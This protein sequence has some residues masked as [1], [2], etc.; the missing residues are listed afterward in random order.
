M[1]D[2][3]RW[4]SAV[5]VPPIRRQDRR[6]AR[7][8]SRRATPVGR[9]T[10]SPWLRA[11]LAFLILVYVGRVHELIPGTSQIPFASMAVLVVVAGLLVGGY[12]SRFSRVIK[13]RTV[14]IAILFVGIAGVSVPF[15]LWMGGALTEWTALA[16]V[17]TICLLLP[18]AV[19]NPGQLTYITRTFV[20]A[21]AILVSGYVVESATGF[22]ALREAQMVTFDKNDV[23]LLAGMAIPFA[24]AWG[25]SADRK[26][27]VGWG[28]GA[29]LAAGVI[30][31]GSRGGFL[32]LACFG[33]IFFL[34]SP[35][36]T[37]GKKVAVVI[38]GT[39]IL[40]VTGSG[41]YWRQIGETFTDPTE[42]YNF[43]VREGRI[44]IW[45]R[46][47]HYLT[48]HPLTGVGIGN[49]PIAEG[50]YLEDEGYG[51]KWSTAHSS[52]VL[53]G[54]ELGIPGLLVFLA[55]L[56]A[57]AGQGRAAPRRFSSAGDPRLREVYRL[58]QATLYSLIVF[59]VAGAFLSAAYSAGPAF[60][61][62]VSAC[63]GCVLID[64]RQSGVPSRRPRP[65]NQALRTIRPRYQKPRTSA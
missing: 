45:K 53:V 5:S 34:R 15:A 16:K 38:I 3:Y 26:R 12:Q 49:F 52:Y 24:V 47:I 42:D 2:R 23:A 8:V 62:G 43:Q 21:A 55:L 29:F 57:I 36:L 40:A 50:Q 7:A 58:S 13:I 6:V 19:V 65:G 11:A 4:Q 64:V 20:V 1:N 59:T 35:M 32:A 63:L 30:S 31:T 54:A 10:W 51:V 17:W 18:L 33:L 25:A 46:G 61:V 9:Y 60:L 28:F 39:A 44:E 48:E 56:F 27:I 41:E 37:T 14:R 22:S